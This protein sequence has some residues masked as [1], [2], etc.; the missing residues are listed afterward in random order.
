MPNKY[1]HVKPSCTGGWD[2]SKHYGSGTGHFRFANGQ[3]VTT[4]NITQA[5]LN[6]LDSGNPMKLQR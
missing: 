3:D 6:Q 1:G 2:L 5:G 4:V